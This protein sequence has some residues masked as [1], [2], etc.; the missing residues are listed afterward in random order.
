MEVNHKRWMAL[1]SVPTP[2]GHQNSWNSFYPMPASGADSTV[3]HTIVCCRIFSLDPYGKWVNGMAD[4]S[5]L[6]VA[7]FH[8]PRG[9]AA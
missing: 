3:V 8:T 7:V 9:L 2:F 5:V 6:P 4:G 1:E